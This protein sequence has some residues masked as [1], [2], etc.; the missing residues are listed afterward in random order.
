MM[1]TGLFL[2]AEPFYPCSIM[3]IE[4]AAN[5]TVTGKKMGYFFQAVRGPARFPLPVF[6]GCERNCIV[7]KN[8]CRGVRYASVTALAIR[9]FPA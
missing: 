1:N 3:I 2:C 5:K 4:D 8:L 7:Y 9:Q 6:Q